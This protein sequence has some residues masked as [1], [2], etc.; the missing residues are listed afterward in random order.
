M[1]YNIRHALGRDGD[2]NLDRIGV[3]LR[4]ESPD[5]V[6]L[7]EV[8]RHVERSHNEHQSERLAD[9][10]GMSAAYCST[11]TIGSGDS[12]L[13]VL[14]RF[15]LASSQKFDFSYL[16]R[17]PRACLRVDLDL[18]VGRILHLFDCHLGL[19]AAERR[20]QRDLMLREVMR[21]GE[22]PGHDVVVLGDFNDWPLSVVHRFLRSHFTDSLSAA[23]RPWAPTFRLGPIPL[24]LD[25]IYVG[26]GIR[27]T[28][29]WIPHGSPAH[30][31]SDHL[32]VVASIDV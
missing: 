29:S 28:D 24:R 3:V 15:P 8:D 13:A 7:Q 10:L 11:Q 27:V 17:E 12:G 18:D 20:Y 2:L 32:P 9:F 6:A 26:P 25:H 19:T 22:E 4:K 14:S 5:V 1:T 31:A 16:R 23:N 21:F 30:I